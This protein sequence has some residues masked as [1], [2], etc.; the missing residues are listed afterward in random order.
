L[1]FANRLLIHGFLVPLLSVAGFAADA[2]SSLYVATSG[3]DS[4]PGTIE[5]PLQTIQQRG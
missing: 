1:S 3:D 5:K 4:N 2:H